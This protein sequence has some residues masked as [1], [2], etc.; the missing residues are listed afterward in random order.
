MGYVTYAISSHSGRDLYY[1]ALYVRDN[2]LKWGLSIVSF[3]IQSYILLSDKQLAVCLST[4]NRPSNLLTSDDDGDDVEF[5][6][7]IGGHWS[8]VGTTFHR[9]ALG[10]KFIAPNWLHCIFYRCTVW[11][12][13]LNFT[14][15]TSVNAFPITCGLYSLLTW[16]LCKCSR[17]WVEVSS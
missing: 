11:I 5:R 1:W 10:R 6:S 14:V 15:L 7:R 4:I 2:D 8:L 13:V 12:K 3:L 16:F 17:V 9:L